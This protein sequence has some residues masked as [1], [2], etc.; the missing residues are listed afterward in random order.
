MQ[1]IARWFGKDFKPPRS[2]VIH[3]KEWIYTD[4]LGNSLVRITRQDINGK[5]TY[6][7]FDFTTQTTSM[8][9][10]HRPLYNQIGLAKAKKLVV[11]EGEKC[12]EALIHSG[13]TATTAMQGSSADPAKT[14][15]T[16]LRD[17]HICIW[18]DNDEVG[19][20]YSQRLTQFLLESKLPQSVTTLNIP[21]DKPP[22]WDAYDA[23]NEG[24]DIVEF[25]RSCPKT[26]N[27]CK[28]GI[29]VAR[30]RDVIADE[31]PEPADIISSG[32]LVQG[33]LMV[34]AGSPKVGKSHVLLSMLVHLSAGIPFLGLNPTHPLKVFYIQ[35][36]NSFHTMRNRLK[37]TIKSLTPEQRDLNDDNMIFTPS[38]LE[39]SLNEHV[40]ND[41]SQKANELQNGQTELIAID[42]LYDVFDTGDKKGGENDNDAMRFF[43]K[44]RLGL[45]R[46][47]INP[48]AGLIL[49]HH[50]KKMRKKDVE[51]NP[52]ESLA[53]ASGLRRYYNS[54]MLLFK[55]D[56]DVNETKIFFE[57][58][59][60]EKIPTK[61]VYR[62]VN[63]GEWEEES[64]NSIRLT[65]HDY[66]K[67]LDAERDR[68]RDVILNI[69]QS[70]AS[71]GNVYTANQFSKTF[72]N[73]A[74]L[75]SEASI[76]RRVS[77][78]MSQGQ[79]KLFKNIKDY[80]LPARR[81]IQRGLM[82]VKDMELQSYN[83]ELRR[84]LPTD[85]KCHKTGAILPV[86]NPNVWVEM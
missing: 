18:A 75:G 59:D 3:R 24:I 67:L 55:E 42:P 82:C 26:R 51:E 57:S 36:E 25:I 68:K 22:K 72:D 52:F 7:P 34:L 47:S 6:T 84:V 16:P 64:A 69:I 48:N 54:C 31:R 40:I 85:Y 66:G 78:L 39:V 1:S 23:I 70:E 30:P 4:R 50:T 56:E 46:R 32:L 71:K 19:L 13:F 33:G 62:D 35:S 41:L 9:Q 11:V 43:L 80:G 12:A 17:K 45:L 2:S 38:R 5:K 53:G 10:T 77:V 21:N 15:W 20:K 81:N 79:I 65:N 73:K 37:Q 86:E 14:D 44:E 29:P 63:T 27:D 28:S 60:G 49:V 58:R 61:H 8:P 83:G 74:S 76:Q